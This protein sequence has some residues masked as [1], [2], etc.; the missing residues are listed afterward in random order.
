MQLRG[1]LVE[2]PSNIGYRLA[3]K[4]VSAVVGVCSSPGHF[5]LG[6]VR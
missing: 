4:Q 3:L 5:G 2:L 6:G 1:S